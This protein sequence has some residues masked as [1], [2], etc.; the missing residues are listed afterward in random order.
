MVLNAANE[1]AVAAFLDNR[2]GFLSIA[3]IV[4]RALADYSSG[5]YSD[6]NASREP[7]S[8]DE[9]LALDAEARA[10]TRELMRGL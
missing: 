3:D 8:V 10:R 7:E 4:G 5:M 6:H 1:E 9:I 2:I